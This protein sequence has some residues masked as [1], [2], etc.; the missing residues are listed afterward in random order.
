MNA[1]PAPQRKVAVVGAKGRMGQTVCRAV[2]DAADL[3]LAGRF[4]VG[5]ELADF[6]FLMDCNILPGMAPI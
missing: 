5:D 4:D 3:A 1:T 6:T 2:A